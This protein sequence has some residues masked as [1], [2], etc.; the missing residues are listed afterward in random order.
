MIVVLG[1][2]LI[3]VLRVNRLWRA[4]NILGKTKRVPGG[5]PIVKVPIARC[6]VVKHP[7]VAFS[8]KQIKNKCENPEIP[9]PNHRPFGH[10]ISVVCVVG[11]SC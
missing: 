2:L 3:F 9:L 1:L 10:G 7:I 6:L 5:Y 4:A 11:W 8:I